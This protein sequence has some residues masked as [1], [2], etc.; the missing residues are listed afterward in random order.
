MFVFAPDEPPFQ[1]QA[2]VEGFVDG[3]LILT[4]LGEWIHANATAHHFCRQLTCDPIR[5]NTIPKAIWQMCESLID[6]R[7]RH[8]E[9]K[10]V[11]EAEVT[12]PTGIM[13]RIRTQW[14][15][16]EIRI[17]P[18]A[19][20]DQSAL[21]NDHPY[22]LVVLEDRSQ[23]AQNLAASSARKYGLTQRQKEVWSLWKL[24]YSY[25]KIATRLYITPHTVKKH[26]KDIR[27]KI[28]EV[29]AWEE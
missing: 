13:L 15:Q 6:N 2:V 18:I 17:A 16:P 1:L 29:Q 12:T 3:I 19:Y 9:Q 23:S 28:L 10:T 7:E 26:L 20:Q 24:G 21:E 25:Q 14:L 22:L 4:E 8:L 5:T 27:A 11:L